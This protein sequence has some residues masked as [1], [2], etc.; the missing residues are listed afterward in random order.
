ME[1]HPVIRELRHAAVAFVLATLSATTTHAQHDAPAPTAAPTTAP[2]TEQPATTTTTTE[3]ATTTAPPTEP[4]HVVD[5]TTLEVNR[6]PLQALNE[7]FLGTAS[8]PVRFDWRK[9]PSMFVFRLNEVQERNSF[10]QW[11]LGLGWR[12]A[13][14]D[15]IFELG[16]N[17]FFAYDTPSSQLLALTPFRQAGRPNHFQLEAN[18][19]YALV[20]GVVTPQWSWLPPMQMVLVGHAGLR[21]LVYVESF[22]GGRS[23]TDVAGSL[24]SPQLTVEELTALERTAPEGMQIDPA[25]LH[26]MVGASLDV[27]VQPGF[28]I[29][30]R[31]SVS[32]PLLSPVTSS[33]IG[34]FWELGFAVGYAL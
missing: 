2:T 7:H 16:A 18:V 13:F 21:Y 10:G 14:D 15:L 6:T 4:A 33:Q 19:G 1:A 8:R 28:L 27:Y 34:F 20:E 3:Q 24:V 25:R 12:R 22:T 26:A 9:S 5:S 32:P 30:P 29:S 17:A 31:V 23:A 11:Q